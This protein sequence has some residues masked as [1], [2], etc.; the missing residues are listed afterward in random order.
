MHV[1]HMFGFDL[2]DFASV[3]TVFRLLLSAV[4]YLSKNTK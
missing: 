3:R 4:I 1:A 2:A